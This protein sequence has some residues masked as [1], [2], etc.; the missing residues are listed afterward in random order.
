MKRYQCIKNMVTNDR[1]GDIRFFTAGKVYSAEKIYGYEQ[2]RDDLGALHIVND[3]LLS[4]FQD[5][6]DLHVDELIDYTDHHVDHD[7][8]EYRRFIES[9]GFSRGCAWAI[10][11]IA[12]AI[13]IMY[14]AITWRS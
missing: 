7:A 8:E 5:L 12:T 11:S 10:V 6:E 3:R 4:H 1:I 13:A 9:V 2:M 14:I